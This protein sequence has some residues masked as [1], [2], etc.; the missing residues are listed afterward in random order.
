MT[1]EDLGCAGAMAVLLK[2]AIQPNL[3]QTLEKHPALVHAGSVCE[4]CSR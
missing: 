1:A 2:D 4:Y 3:L